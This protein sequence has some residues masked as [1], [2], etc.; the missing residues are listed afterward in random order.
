MNKKDRA[1]H[2]LP[3]Q[4]IIE[5]PSKIEDDPFWFFRLPE[6]NLELPVPPKMN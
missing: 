4:K 1:E 6:E 5:R 3:E 2:K